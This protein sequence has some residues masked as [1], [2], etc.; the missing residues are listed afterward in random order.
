[1]LRCPFG[2]ASGL[3]KGAHFFIFENQVMKMMYTRI[4]L[5][6]LVVLGWSAAGAQDA[7][8][9]Q[10]YAS[11]LTLNPAMTGIFA[12]QSRFAVNYR[13]LYS[14]LLGDEAYKTIAGSFDYRYQVG[15]MDYVGIGVVA[16]RDQVGASNF[17]RTEGGLSASY[18]KHLGGGRYR[19]SDQ[20]LVVGAQLGSG[21]RG[22]DAE[23]L[24]F[25]NQFFVDEASRQAYIDY[26]ASSQESFADLRTNLYL[27]F[28][29]GLLWYALFDDDASIYV[30][31]A[32]FHLTE[33]NISFMEDREEQLYRKWVAH[34]GGQLPL[35][36]EISLLP[37]ASVMGQGPAF[38]ATGGLNLRYANHDWRDVAI[39]AGAWGH[40]SNQSDKMGLDAVIF[41]AILEMERW[42]LG[43]SYDMTTSLLAGANNSRGAFEMS[44]IYTQPEKARQRRVSCPRF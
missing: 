21:Q 20:Y 9:A 25:S 43:F 40:L 42:Q 13:T 36:R 30:G 5:L 32:M 18:L 19:S 2:R 12:G 22:F 8:F 11:P 3:T 33:P 28:N 37:A 38:S 27:D 39:R 31:G 41:S 26:A 10:F 29:A 44:L 16:L 34:A 23:K 1:M 6:A 7:R 15:R 17:S 35:T 24:W 14:S 4:L